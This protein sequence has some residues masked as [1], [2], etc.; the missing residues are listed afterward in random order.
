MTVSELIAVLKK[1][2]QDAHLVL[3]NE[4]A[5]YWHMPK[6]EVWRGGNEDAWVTSDQRGHDVVV[7]VRRT[8]A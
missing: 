6:F 1:L 2:P 5:G 3:D 7:I 8:K 4:D